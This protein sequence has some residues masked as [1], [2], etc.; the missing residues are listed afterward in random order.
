[1]IADFVYSPVTDYKSFKIR[2]WDHDEDEFYKVGGGTQKNKTF[3][4]IN[5]FLWTSVCVYREE[6]MAVIGIS[7]IIIKNL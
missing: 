7:N 5:H 1:M 4:R 6:R 2:I 3:F